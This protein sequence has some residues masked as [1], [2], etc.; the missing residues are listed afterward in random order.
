MASAKIPRAAYTAVGIFLAFFV[1]WLATASAYWTNP[2]SLQRAWTEIGRFTGLV[3]GILAIAAW[4]FKAMGARIV[5]MIVFGM[6]LYVALMFTG[7]L[8]ACSYG[9]CL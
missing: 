2:F 5:S 3:I 1:V 6:F 9:D 4:P 8:T 7:L